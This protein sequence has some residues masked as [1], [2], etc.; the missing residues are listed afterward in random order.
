[1]R[2]IC[3]RNF[4]PIYSVHTVLTAAQALHERGRAIALDLVGDGPLRAALQAQ[5]DAAGLTALT[6]FHGHVD[7]QRLVQLLG[8]AHVFVT[9]A[10]SDGNNV[11]LNEAM[12]CGTF[13]IATDIAAN[14]QWIQDGDNGLLYAAGDAAALA[15]C[16]DRV[17]SA[18]A[19]RDRAA[20]ENRA[21]V[22]ARADWRSSVEL[23]AT[24]YDRI[25]S[26]S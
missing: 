26:E 18:G 2:I 4:A 13:P 23:M 16:V 24:I 25:T 1:M 22:E 20:H 15:A 9:P 12:A 7:H 5:A 17:L 11:S 14:R 3:T 6:T 8:Q 21:I 19:W 10:L